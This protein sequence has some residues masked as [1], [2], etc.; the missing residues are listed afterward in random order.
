MTFA[1]TPLQ[2][3]FVIELEKRGDDR[4][5]RYNDPKFGIRR[6]DFNPATHFK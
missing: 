2:G 4:C 5:R 1:D 3:A 6:P